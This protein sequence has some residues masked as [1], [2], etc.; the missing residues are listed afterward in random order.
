[1]DYCQ[2][3]ADI[4]LRAGNGKVVFVSGNFNIVHPGHLRLLKFARDC[5]DVLVV[6]VCADGLKEGAILKE[7]ERLEGVSSNSCVDYAFVLYCQPEEFIAQL[8]PAV[9]VKGKEHEN[10]NNS[11]KDIVESYGG[12]LLFSSGDVTYSSLELLEKEYRSINYSSIQNATEYF[13]RHHFSIS[14]LIETIDGFKSLQVMVIG[15]SIV[16]EYIDCDPLGMSREETALVITPVQRKFFVGGAAIV[17]SHARALGATVDFFSVIGKDE[18][19]AFLSD[20]LDEYKVNGHLF[21]D[22]SRP[23]SLKQRFR[24]DGHSLLRVSH[25]KQHD[26]NREMQA[27]ILNDFRCLAMRIDLVIFS[28][29]NYGCLPQELVDGITKICQEHRIKMVADSQSSSQN[30]DVSRFA[31]TDLLTPT[32]YEARL[33]VRDFKSGLVVLAE[34]LRQKSEGHHILMT[35]GEAG[36][37]IH[38]PGASGLAWETDRLPAMNTAPQDV[39]GAGDSLLTCASLALAVGRDIWESAYLGSLAAACQVSRVGNT[40]LS[41]AEIIAELNRL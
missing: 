8:K 28:D 9:V 40:P 33:A 30:G 1:M 22:D 2:L 34:A 32:E 15:D 6:G 41:N 37:L 5:G 4:R 23:T 27:Q 11:E 31:H 35:L 26:I 13:N 14:R 17:A 7:Q 39:A 21:T 38:T 36:V 20:H 12:K 3:I 19:A 25:L 18:A 10:S 24:V 16:D 29:F